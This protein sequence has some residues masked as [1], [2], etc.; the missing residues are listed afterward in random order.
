MK[1]FARAMSFLF[2][3]FFFSTSSF[4]WNALGH[5]IVAQIAYQHLTPEAQ[6]QIDLLIGRFH[7]EYPEIETF[8]QAAVWPDAIRGQKIESY[9]HWHYID[10]SIST[11]NSPLKNLMDTDNAEWAIYT[12]QPVIKN[13]NA[14]P[15]ER[16]RFLAFLTH[17]VGDL[18]QP[19]HTVSNITTKNPDGDKGGNLH[20]VYVK[21]E[22][23]NLHHLWDG[24]VGAFEGES[25]PQQAVISANRIMQAYPE[26]FF[27]NRAKDLNTNDWSKEGYHLAKS[28]VYSAPEEQSLPSSYLETNNLVCQQQV[29]LAGYRLAKIL[30]SL[31]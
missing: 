6:K 29:A 19:L 24:G 28:E 4:A 25:T 12:I 20:Y 18:H 13:A 17:I 8:M 21:N 14:N 30:N 11:D 31:F 26:S 7:T 16:V 22:R 5:M 27:A 9:T 2:V 23:M 3:G 10:Y 1:S 15:Y